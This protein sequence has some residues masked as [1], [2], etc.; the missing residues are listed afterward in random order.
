M[1]ATKIHLMTTETQNNYKDVCNNCKTI[2]KRTKVT[3]RPQRDT[4]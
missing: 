1:T 2:I 4:K 3:T